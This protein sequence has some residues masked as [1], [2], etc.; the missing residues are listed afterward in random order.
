MTPLEYTFAGAILV[1]IWAVLR[2]RKALDGLASS[3]RETYVAVATLNNDRS[4]EIADL[5][6]KKVSRSE[7]EADTA[8]LSEQTLKN[9]EAV[10]RLSRA[11]R[12]LTP[13]EILNAL[14]QKE[15]FNDLHAEKE[16]GE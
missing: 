12:K 1:L 15:R 5:S 7:F 6:L 11:V 3:V 14:E 9:A 10:R 8:H 13:E 16:A 4:A 2:Q